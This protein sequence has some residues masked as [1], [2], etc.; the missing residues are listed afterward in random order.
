MFV[1][2]CQHCDRLATCPQCTLPLGLAPA[3]P[4]PMRGQAVRIING[5][6]DGM[7]GFNG[8]V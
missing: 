4:Q 3:L 5:W 7:V 1:S 2:I 6:M 8:V